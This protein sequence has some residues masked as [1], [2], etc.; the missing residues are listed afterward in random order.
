MPLTPRLYQIPKML[1]AAGVP[2]QGNAFDLPAD[3]PPCEICGRPWCEPQMH[4]DERCQIHGWTCDPTT[5]DAN[6]GT[7]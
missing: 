5:H 7:K 6:G 1:P 3:L 4:P 2:N